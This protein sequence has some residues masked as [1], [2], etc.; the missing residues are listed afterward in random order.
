[1]P[2]D[3]RSSSNIHRQDVAPEPIRSGATGQLLVAGAPEDIGDPSKCDHGLKICRLRSCIQ[4]WMLDHV[5]YWDRTVAGRAVRDTAPFDV[6]A[7]E[8]DIHQAW[9][10]GGQLG[11][12]R[13]EAAWREGANQTRGGP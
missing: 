8:R 1:M 6:M 11:I 7:Y 2:Y 4:T 9:L 13:V 3:Y 12:D 5:I 10:E